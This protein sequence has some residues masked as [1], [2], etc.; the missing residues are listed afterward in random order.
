MVSMALPYSLIPYKAEIKRKLIHLSSLWMPAVMYFLPA[1]TA[2][3]IFAVLLVKVLVFEV[4]R[5]QHHALARLANRIFSPVLRPQE[6]GARFRLTGATFVLLAALLCSI[7]FPT[8]VAV[9][10][11]SIMLVGDAAASLIG[12]RYGRTPMLGKT[13]EGS[14]AFLMTSLITIAVIG[15]LTHYQQHFYSGALV[16]AMVATLTELFS[17][18]LHIDDNLSIPLAAGGAM[19]L[20]TSLL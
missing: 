8:P 10:A 15:Q 1:H 13:V 6:T 3:A 5:R 2:A 14:V 11:M 4:V 12:R 16:A 18:R 7:L 19:W 9:T 17:G 20:V